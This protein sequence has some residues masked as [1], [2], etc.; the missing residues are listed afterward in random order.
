VTVALFVAAA[1]AGTLIR[2]A[3]EHRWAAAATLTVNI[4]GAL[5]LGLIANAGPAVLA[6]VGT[7]ALGALTT[8]SGLAR[9]AFE[10][11]QRG[12]RAAAVAYVAV[13]VV[14]GVAAAALGLALAP[15]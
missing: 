14:A 8:F 5:A 2:W 9:V 15:D 13:T 12:Q 1:A 3:A 7:G 6:V 11:D 10:M 4:L